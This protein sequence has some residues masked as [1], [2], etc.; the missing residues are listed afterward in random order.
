MIFPESGRGISEALY[1]GK[2]A[3][4]ADRPQDQ[5]IADSGVVS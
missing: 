3:F 4:R 2:M 5:D 1:R